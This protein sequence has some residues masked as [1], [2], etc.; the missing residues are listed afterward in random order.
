MSVAYNPELNLAS[1]TQEMLE[2]VER[3]GDAG[4]DVLRAMKEIARRALPEGATTDD[5]FEIIVGAFGSET[6]TL[7]YLGE[8]A[9]L[10][11]PADEDLKA[12]LDRV[13]TFAEQVRDAGI[14][15][16]LEIIFER[17][18]MRHSDAS[19][20]FRLLRAIVGKFDGRVTFA[21]LNYD[22]LLLAALIHLY[23]DSLADM[24]QGNRSGSVTTDGVRYNVP[25][26][27]RRGDL[28]DERRLRLLHL[29]GS[30]TYWTNR[31]RTGFVKLDRSFL[32]THSQWVAVREGQTNVRPV[33]VLA[34][35]RDKQAHVEDFPF[36]LAY[37]MFAASIAETN[38]WLIVGYSFRDAC[39]NDVMREQ[40]RS[41]SDKPT[42]LVST[43]G[44]SPS[45]REVEVALGW[46]AE[47][48]DSS[49]R[50]LFHRGGAFD[51]A[52]SDEWS[53]FSA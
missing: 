17:S 7:G 16:V 36:S 29:H 48:G 8:L 33:V 28:P 40:F 37:E 38:R 42:V 44:D 43:F 9:T 27:R 11:S 52:S 23:R 51:L 35:Q 41:R 25:P 19:G 50:I 2:R 4:S 53:T 45:R 3:E 39:V 14:S 10:T 6:R 24:A 46:G 5:D 20:L 26:L 32:Q 21:N 34:N 49:Q 1:I 30:L 22:T 15:R 12:A 13:T 47:D 18:K 31:E